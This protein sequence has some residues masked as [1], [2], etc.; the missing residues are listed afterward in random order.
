MVILSVL[1]LSDLF[2]ALQSC[3][4]D[5]STW[6][7]FEVQYFP[8]SLF[9]QIFFQEK[10]RCMWFVQVFAFFSFLQEEKTESDEL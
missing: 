1:T 8:P 6:E 7:D 2:C 4:H 9:A 10:A 3:S 5:L